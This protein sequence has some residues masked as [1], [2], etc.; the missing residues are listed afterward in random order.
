MSPGVVTD[1]GRR[2]SAERSEVVEGW[3]RA[4]QHENGLDYSDIEA[5]ILFGSKLRS[6]V[7]LKLYSFA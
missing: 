6:Y 2:F 1:A 3:S 4:W 7:P 5:Y